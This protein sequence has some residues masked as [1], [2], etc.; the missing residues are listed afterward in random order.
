MPIDS[1]TPKTYSTVQLKLVVKTKFPY[2]SLSF[3][4]PVSHKF[5][6][7]KFLWNSFPNFPPPL[8]WGKLISQSVNPVS[9]LGKHNSPIFHIFLPISPEFPPNFPEIHQFSPEFPRNSS[10]LPEFPQNSPRFPDDSYWFLLIPQFPMQFSLHKCRLQ[11]L[12][13]LGLFY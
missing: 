9:P 10:I 13:A 3:P 8:M 2:I 7:G 12:W 4:P 11:R 6:W 5:P 1:Q